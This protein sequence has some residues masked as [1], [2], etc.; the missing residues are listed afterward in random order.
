[1]PSTRAHDCHSATMSV[2]SSALKEGKRESVIAM[3]EHDRDRAGRLAFRRLHPE[4]HAEIG[5]DRK[6]DRHLDAAHAPAAP[7]PARGSARRAARVR[8]PP[9]RWPRTAP[10]ERRGRAAHHGSTRQAWP[11]R[12]VFDASRLCSPPGFPGRWPPSEFV[13]RSLPQTCRKRFGIRL[14]FLVNLRYQ[15][16]PLDSCLMGRCRVSSICCNRSPNR[17]NRS[18]NPRNVLTA[19]SIRADRIS[20]N[21]SWPP[22]AAPAPMPPMRSRCAR[23]R[24]RRRARRRGRGIERSESDDVGLRV[25]VGRRT[26][27]SRPTTSPATSRRSPSARWRWRRSR[28]RTSSP[29]SPIP[30]CSRHASRSRSARSG[31]AVGRR[32]RGAR[33]R[34]EAAAL[35]VKGVSKSD[36]ASASAGIGGM[37]LVTSHGF[38]GAYLASRSGFSMSAIAGEGTAMETDYDYSSALHAADLESPEK[39]GRTAGER[40]V[41]RLNPRKVETTQGAGRLRPAGGELAG[42]ASR[43]RDQRQRG[44]AQDELPQGQ[45]RRAAVPAGHPHH[46]RSAAQARPALAAVRR[47]GRRRRAAAR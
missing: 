23:C 32:A 15:I 12:S 47:R 46:R 44:R 19:R 13:P 9:C 10:V 18:Q 1:M 33:P 28:P 2:P 25:F 11:C 7:R 20:P 34:A 39:V 4:R 37:V 21:V 43:R 22:R 16:G 36:G 35:A 30:R 8:R 40:A 14:M 17:A 26:R 27:W 42:R 41:A 31:S 5:G 29:A 38:R 3:L 45:A 24:S 6:V